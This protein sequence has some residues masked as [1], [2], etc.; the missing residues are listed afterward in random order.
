[1]SSFY[2]IYLLFYM[3]VN[4]TCHCRLGSKKKIFRSLLHICIFFYS[5]FISVNIFSQRIR[6]GNFLLLCTQDLRGMYK[7]QEY[8]MKN[9]D[10]YIHIDGNEN[11]KYMYIAIVLYN[12]FKII[13]Y[14]MIYVLYN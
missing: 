2:F 3:S 11:R 1:M 12:L 13:K 8:R 6:L 7:A 5:S 14:K 4:S 9:I 10:V